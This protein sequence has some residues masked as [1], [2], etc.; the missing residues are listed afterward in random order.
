MSWLLLVLNHIRLYY[1]NMSANHPIRLN[2]KFGLAQYDILTK[3]RERYVKLGLI[4]EFRVRCNED[5]KQQEKYL[6]Y[7]LDD[8]ILSVNYKMNE[9]DVAGYSIFNI[10]SDICSC[11]RYFGGA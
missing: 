2:T 10:Q 11:L 5:F 8:D 9:D 4:S 1:L 3:Q 7:F 6:E